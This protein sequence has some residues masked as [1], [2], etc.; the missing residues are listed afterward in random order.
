[1]WGGGKVLGTGEGLRRGDLGG[2]ETGLTGGRSG[3]GWG[4]GDGEV[5]FAVELGLGGVIVWGLGC[6]G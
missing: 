2:E 1:M 6:G 3:R 5:R 4:V